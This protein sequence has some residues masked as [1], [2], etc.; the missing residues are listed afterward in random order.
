[1]SRL[2]RCLAFSLTIL[3]FALAAQVPYVQASSWHLDSA[4]GRNGVAGLPVRE[5]ARGSLLAPGP[6][7]SIFVGG[8]ADRKKGAF[9]IARLSASGRL[10]KS[11]GSGGVSTVPALYSFPQDPPRVFALGTG[12][13]II[14]GLDRS[15]RLTVVRLTAGGRPDRSFAD[16]GVARYKLPGVHGFAVITAAAV[17][18]GGEILAV[19]QREVPQ[20]V[21]EP[22]IPEGLGEGPI[23]LVRLL[24]SGKLDR[25]FGQAG[26]LEAAGETPALAGYPGNGAGWA[27]EQAIGADG[28]VLL[29]YEQAVGGTNAEVPA[30]QELSPTGADAPGF[31]NHGAAYLPFVPKAGG[32]SSSLCDG[33]FALG[34]GALEA[35]FGGEGLSADGAHVELFR[36]T[37]AGALDPSFGGSGYTIVNRPVAALALA[38]LG[39]TLSAGLSGRALVVGGTLA[40]G[41]PD[42]ALGGAGGKRF[43]TNLSAPRSGDASQT[44]ELLPG[45]TSMS[46]RVGEEIVRI[47]R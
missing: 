11:F 10:V 4:F 43:A 28:S 14:A 44:L 12:E 3:G 38:P 2:S 35:G 32:S 34:H 22:R 30:V 9:L 42:P 39:E 47:S 31:G 37:P 36:F 13:L 27:C 15:D 16:N 46:I 7:G 23:G 26:F 25:S 8:Y 5:N 20:P 24:G 6:G 45:A 41:A 18:P 17:E 33:L 40:N 21:N 19:Y 1:V 29:A